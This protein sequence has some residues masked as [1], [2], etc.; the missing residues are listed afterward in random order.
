MADNSQSSARKWLK[1]S[2]LFKVLAKISSIMLVPYG[3]FIG[4]L[5]L[6]PHGDAPALYREL[7]VAIFALGIIYYFPN[8]QIA[9]SGKKIFLYFGATISPIVFLFFAA[10]KTIMIEDV[11]SFVASGGIVTFLIMVPV[12]SLAPLSLWAFIKGAGRHKIS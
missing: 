12:F 7:G 6:A 5:G 4:F 3:F 11:W 9:T 10:L 8:S 2:Q 1:V